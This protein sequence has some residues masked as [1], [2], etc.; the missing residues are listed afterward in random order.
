[1]KHKD[2]VEQHSIGNGFGNSNSKRFHLSH[3]S[4]S[5][6]ELWH[7]CSQSVSQS[8]SQTMLI[9]MILI[10]RME[11]TLGVDN[12]SIETRLQFLIWEMIVV[13]VISNASNWPLVVVVAVTD[14]NDDGVKSRPRINC[15][16]KGKMFSTLKLVY[17][18]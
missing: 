9:L 8:S 15:L 17:V 18:C 11:I 5:R 14:R 12:K 4:I 13:C 3:D 10:L 2:T 1:M 6:D 7:S 16:D